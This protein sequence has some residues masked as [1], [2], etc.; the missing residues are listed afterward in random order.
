MSHA[1]CLTRLKGPDITSSKGAHDP[2]I[3]AGEP[4][5]VYRIREGNLL[6]VAM[7]VP[8][9]QLR[10]RLAGTRRVSVDEMNPANSREIV[11]SSTNF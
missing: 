3:E 6:L 10:G 9:R 11:F 1:N 5:R 2:G 4:R 8:L 7:N